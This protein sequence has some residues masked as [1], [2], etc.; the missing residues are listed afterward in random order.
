MLVGTKHELSDLQGE[1][2]PGSYNTDLWKRVLVSLQQAVWATQLSC[3]IYN[4]FPFSSL[5]LLVLFFPLYIAVFKTV[6]HFQAS[7]AS[8]FSPL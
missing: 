4:F 8:S 6:A 3:Y 7:Y 1:T 5:F 2:V